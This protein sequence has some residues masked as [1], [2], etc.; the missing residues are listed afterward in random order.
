MVG[1]PEQFNRFTRDVVA[2]LQDRGVFRREYEDTTLR[3]NLE[4]PKP[5][6]IRSAA[7]SNRQP[8][9]RQTSRLAS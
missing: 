3:G 9:E 6:N 4:L 1:H 8:V 2:V 7:V 5:A